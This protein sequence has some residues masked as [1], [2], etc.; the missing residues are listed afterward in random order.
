VLKVIA[1]AVCLGGLAL[2]C[3][4]AEPTLVYHYEVLGNGDKV[5][6]TY[7]VNQQDL[8]HT[9]V[10]LPWASEEFRGTKE[11][12]VRVEADGPSG[13]RVRCVLRYRPVAGE[14]GGDGSGAM[15]QQATAEDD[16]TVCDLD[17]SSIVP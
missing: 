4:E 8:V 6:V 3:E 14:Y 5:K 15:S 17:Q 10:R 13:S 1:L 12:P 2:A 7:L 9:T 11:T 16:Q